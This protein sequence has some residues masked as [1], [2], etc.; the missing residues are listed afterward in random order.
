VMLGLTRVGQWARMTVS[1]N[2]VGI[3]PESLSRVFDRFYR[4][5]AARSR[6]S[7]GAGLGLAIAQHIAAAHGGRI[8]AASDGVPGRGAVF[9]VWLPLDA[10]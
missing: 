7:G 3:P 1:D 9:S 5:D 10:G 4:V 6:E 2:G 8:E